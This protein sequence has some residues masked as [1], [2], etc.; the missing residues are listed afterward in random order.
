[1]RTFITSLLFASFFAA[2]AQNDMYFPPVGSDDWETVTPEEIGWCST[3]LDTLSNFLE[4]RNTNAFILLH[5]GRIV[6]E[7]YFNDF[8]EDSVWVWNS[9]GK[10]ITATMAGIAQEER[11]LTLDDATNTYLGEGWTNLTLE[12]ESAITIWNQLT[13]TSGLDDTEVDVFCTDPECLTYLEPPGDRWAYHNGPYTL[14]QDV[15][16]EAAGSTMNLYTYQQ[17][18]Q[19]TGMTGLFLPIGY[20]KIFVSKPRSM[21]RFGLLMQNKGIWDGTPVLDDANFFQEMVNPT[22]DLNESY[23]YLWWLNGYDSYQL[24]GIQLE[25]PGSM[26]PSAPDDMFAALGADSQVI[27]VVPSMD[28]V[29]IRMG[30]SPDNSLLPVTFNVELW[31]VLDFLFCDFP[32]SVEEEQ[33]NDVSVYPNPSSTNFEIKGASTTS[34]WTLFNQ[35]GTQVL[36]GTGRIVP[37]NQL[38]GGAYFLVVQDGEALSRHQVV[39]L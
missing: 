31:E 29:L 32:D 5:Q 33:T 1:M 23:G 7:E 28:L 25:I 34:S 13:M 3:G 2:T 21:A 10:T 9:A 8:H 38:A 24:P 30:S 27:H 26:V 16:G 18:L 4:D 15:I 12:Q 36:S 20:N 19:P 11:L 14:L 35:L 22:Q 6:V 39:V 37:V 17:L